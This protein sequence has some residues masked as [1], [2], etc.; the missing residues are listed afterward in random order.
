MTVTKR[1]QFISYPKSGRTWLRFALYR[2]GFR[3]EIRFHHDGFEFNDAAKPLP[4]FNLDAR[5]TR[6]D[7]VP[8]VYLAREPRDILVSLYFQVTGRFRDVF[9]Y[10]GT[11]SDFIRDEYFGA[12]TLKRFRDQWDILCAEGRA[13]RIDYEACHSDF[14]AVLRAVI[15]HYGWDV[16]EEKLAEAVEAARFENMKRVEEAGTFD[17]PWLRP[18]N[19]APKV[20]RGVVGGYADVLT[21]EDLRYLDGIF[22]E[23]R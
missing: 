6:F 16:P 23:R 4:D 11:I 8:V 17:F 19:G 10:R 22:G 2:L 9:D 7:G 13:L 20:R 18:R 14:P 15:R 12:D 3:R 21:A 5:R 1:P